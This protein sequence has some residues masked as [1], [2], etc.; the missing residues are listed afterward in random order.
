MDGFT[1]P[2]KV[3]MLWIFIVLKNP[4]PSAVFEL[5]NLGYSGK[6]ANH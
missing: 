5:A 1:S 4:S 2:P 3:G 6:Y